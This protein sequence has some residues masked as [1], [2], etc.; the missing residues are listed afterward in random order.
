MD[1]QFRFITFILQTDQTCLEIPYLK[2]RNN[3]N[4][5]EGK[6]NKFV[7]ILYYII[8]QYLSTLKSKVIIV[9]FSVCQTFGMLEATRELARKKEKENG[10]G[11]GV[12]V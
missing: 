9:D 1:K 5:H 8:M 10:K 4:F 3:E 6:T 11:Q 2:Y 7:Y 12:T